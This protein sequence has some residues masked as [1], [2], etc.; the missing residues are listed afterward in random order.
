MAFGIGREVVCKLTT[1]KYEFGI[2]TMMVGKK[3]RTAWNVYEAGFVSPEWR[4]EWR[5][6]G[7][8]LN[9]P[10]VELFYIIGERGSNET[11]MAKAPT[12]EQIDSLKVRNA[13]EMMPVIGVCQRDG[14]RGN[15]IQRHSDKSF[16]FIDVRTVNEKSE[17]FFMEAQEK[18]QKGEL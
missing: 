2:A 5:K 1:D 12:I 15:I 7:A 9:G 3:W 4:K 6:L 14:H 18:H 16:I 8:G 13:E 10:A 17:R 11:E